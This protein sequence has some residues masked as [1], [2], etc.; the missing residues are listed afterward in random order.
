MKPYVIERDHHLRSPL[1]FFL[2]SLR[3]KTGLQGSV[4]GTLYVHRH[5]S[6]YDLLPSSVEGFGRSSGSGSGRLASS[7]D[8]TRDYQTKC[9]SMRRDLCTYPNPSTSLSRD[10]TREDREDHLTPDPRVCP[11]NVL[12][13]TQV[14]GVLRSGSLFPTELPRNRFVCFGSERSWWIVECRGMF[15]K[16]NVFIF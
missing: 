14:S 8:G 5:P 2:F 10:E 9:S 13:E 6:M 1:F 16:T 4:T 12:V 11:E 15:D 3:P 7:H